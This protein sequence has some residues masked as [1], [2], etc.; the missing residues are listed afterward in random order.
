LRKRL[1][2]SVEIVENERLISGYG[3]PEISFAIQKTQELFR[4]LKKARDSTA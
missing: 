3:R 2:E 1:V 4:K